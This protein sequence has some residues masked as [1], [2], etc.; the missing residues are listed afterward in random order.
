MAPRARLLPGHLIDRDFARSQRW[1]AASASTPSTARPL[2]RSAWL[3]CRRPRWDWWAIAA[4]AARLGGT[5]SGGSRAPWRGAPGRCRW[6]WRRRRRRKTRTLPRSP[7][8]EPRR[9]VWSSPATCSR[10]GARWSGVLG[11][12]PRALES[13]TLR[14]CPLLTSV[15][16]ASG[17]LRVLELLGC[18]AVRELRVAAPALES[19]RPRLLQRGR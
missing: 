10:P 15:S 5:S 9:S 7:I 18:R 13:L 6:T 3:W 17:R 2:R 19:G 14:S 4:A 11:S 1:A 8:A 12:W 16:V